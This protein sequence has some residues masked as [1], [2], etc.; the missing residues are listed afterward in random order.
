MKD[1]YVESIYF[2]L[3]VFFVLAVLGIELRAWHMLSYIPSLWEVD[4]V[5]YIYIYICIYIYI[6]I[7]IY[8]HIYNVHSLKP[9]WRGPFV[10]IL[11]NTPTAVKIVV[12]APWIHHSQV[13]PA[14]LQWECIPD[15]LHH[16]G[17]PSEPEHLPSAELCF[18]GNNRGPKTTDDSPVLVSLEPD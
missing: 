9:R 15:Q 14:S 11:S 6:Y 2:L 18:P 4:S 10:V 5:I 8:I 3:V 7:Y 16:A 12:I 1:W 17:S 13:K